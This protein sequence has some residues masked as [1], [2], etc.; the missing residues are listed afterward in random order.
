[1]SASPSGDLA[2]RVED[3]VRA[4]VLH[5]MPPDASGE[6]A[7]KPVRE[8]LHIYGNWR[9]RHPYPRSRVV[10]R[11]QEI[12]ASAEALAFQSRLDELVRKME[13]GEELN[14]T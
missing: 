12:L 3:S 4:Y 13:V 8:L 1:M 2:D 14:L 7:A 5:S 9:G 6:L 10:H 11:S